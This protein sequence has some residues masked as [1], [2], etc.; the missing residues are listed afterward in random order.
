LFGLTLTLSVT[1]IL[2]LYLLVGIGLGI[3]YI[4]LCFSPSFIK[5]MPKPGAW[6]ETLKQVLAFP[7]LL[8]VVYFVAMIAPDY[9]IAT[10][11]LLIVVWF[12][13]WFIGRVPAYAEAGRIRAA[14]A[15]GL[16]T[17][18]VGAVIGFAFFGPTKHDVPW[19]P[20]NEAVLAKYRSEGKTVMIEF[21][22]R[23]CL[24]CQSNMKFAIDRPQVAQLVEKNEVVPLLADWSEPSDEILSKLKELESLSIPLLAI[25]PADPGADPIVLRDAITESQL[26]DALEQAGPSSG[27]SETKTARQPAEVLKLTSHPE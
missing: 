10:L 6:M 19:I 25:Y 27:E 15:A 13:C 16:A 9:R 3:P 12:A 5:M 21:T 18:A 7:L 17:T 11:I 4:A 22:A 23:W 1:S 20:Y 2:L 8:T 14:W 26:I 24:T